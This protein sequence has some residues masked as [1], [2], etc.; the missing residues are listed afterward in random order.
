MIRFSNEG[1]IHWM[2]STHRIFFSTGFF[3]SEDQPGG[4]IQVPGENMGVAKLTGSKHWI[5]LE[6]PWIYPP[7]SNSHH[8]D[9]YIFSRESL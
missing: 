4:T 3:R 7:R 9:Y 2:V 5:S 8:Q 6:I 1:K